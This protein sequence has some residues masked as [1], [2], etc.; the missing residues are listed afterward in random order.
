MDIGKMVAYDTLVLFFIFFLNFCDHPQ[1][2]RKKNI[3]STFAWFMSLSC[4]NSLP[5]LIEKT[6]TPIVNIIWRQ[7]NMSFPAGSKQHG[8]K[9]NNNKALLGT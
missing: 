7:K 2:T 3:C 6:Y 5:C 8:N 4:A 9:N 1:R